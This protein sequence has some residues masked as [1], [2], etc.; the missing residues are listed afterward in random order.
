MCNLKAED[1]SVDL[2]DRSPFSIGVLN[3]IMRVKL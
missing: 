2:S 3:H 1:L